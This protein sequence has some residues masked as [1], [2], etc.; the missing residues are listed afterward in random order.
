MPPTDN[1]DRVEKRGVEE[2]VDADIDV[3]DKTE[4]TDKIVR[5]VFNLPHPVHHPHHYTQ[6]LSGTHYPT[7]TSESFPGPSST[8]K[9]S[10]ASRSSPVHILPPEAREVAVEQQKNP[11]CKGF[12]IHNTLIG[13][14]VPLGLLLIVIS[15][16]FGR[17]TYRK[18]AEKRREAKKEKERREARK[19]RRA[20]EA[21]EAECWS[22]LYRVES[23]RPSWEDVSLE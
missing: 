5:A 9:P 3:E 15:G 17:R 21:R 2:V 14:L 18:C 4:E 8:H 19:R 10:P 13:I 23:R 1:R 20:I 7:A 12:M 16:I 22:S 6:S 11:G